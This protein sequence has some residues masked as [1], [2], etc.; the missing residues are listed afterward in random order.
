MGLHTVASIYKHGKRWR[1]QVLVGSQRQGKVFDT[2]AEASQWALQMEAEGK[3]PL[4]VSSMLVRDAAKK[5][6]G[7]YVNED[8]SR[9]DVSRAKRLQDDPI[10]AKRLV[11]VSKDDLDE[12]R[13]RRLAEVGP[14]S[15]R[16]ELNLIRGMFRRC[17]EDWKWMSHNPFQSFKAPKSPDARMRRVTDEEIQLVRHAFNVGDTLNATTIANRVG[18]AFLFAIETAMRSG[19]ICALEW[20]RVY[21]DKRYAHL[22]KTKNGD[23]RD[24]PL[25]PFACEILEALPREKGQPCFL[26]D[27]DQRDAN[28]RKWRD[29]LPVTDL[30]FHDTRSEG[31]W[32]LS[33]KLDVLQLARAIGHRDINSLLIYYR[34][35]AEDMAAKL[36]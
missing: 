32:R 10:A 4:A 22:P 30:H 19:E 15:V 25:S 14:A 5:L 2:K 18:L 9:S 11:D 21:L 17:R 8:K 7:L 31:I 12:Y 20:E 24:V 36:I 26:M 33:K 35:S 34:E 23:K 6:H 29:K 3:K 27:D 13:D 28:W 16:R 1:A